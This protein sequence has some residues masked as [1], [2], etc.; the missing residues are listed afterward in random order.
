MV[1]SLKSVRS[2]L[3]TKKRTIKKKNLDGKAK[4]HKCTVHRSLVSPR[5]TKN[6]LLKQS[7]KNINEIQ[8][9]APLVSHNSY[10]G[11]GT[12]PQE[13]FGGIILDTRAY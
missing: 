12:K 7:L 1:A 13:L 6:Y 4:N 2:E 9:T 3:N 5:N 11:A 10:N 8:E